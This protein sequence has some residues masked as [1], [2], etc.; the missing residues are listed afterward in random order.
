V[1]REARVPAGRS[2]P[3]TSGA[4]CSPALASASYSGRPSSNSR[5]WPHSARRGPAC[6]APCWWALAG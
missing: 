5:S 4:A 6:S 1:I 2:T 3:R